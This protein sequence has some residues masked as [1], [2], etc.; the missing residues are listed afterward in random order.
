MARTS[1]SPS[2]SP[3]PKIPKHRKGRKDSKYFTPQELD[4]M[5]D[6]KRDF[7]ALSGR[8]AAGRSSYIR[9][10]IFPVMI[11]HWRELGAHARIVE[12]NGLTEKWEKLI[13]KY[14]GK[15]WRS[16]IPTSPLKPP[17]IHITKSNFLYNSQRK[18]VISE[19]KDLLE[20]EELT[21]RNVSKYRHQAVKRI[22]ARMDRE[23]LCKLEEDI[24]RAKTSGYTFD[25]KKR[26]YL[27]RCLQQ[28][29]QAH[30]LQHIEMGTFSFQVS[31]F[32][33]ENGD[34]KLLIHKH[35]AEILDARGQWDFWDECRPEIL[36]I[37]LAYENYIKKL[38]LA[39]GQGPRADPNTLNAELG[40]GP[41]T[42]QAAVNLESTPSRSLAERQEHYKVQATILGNS[43][44][45][46][47]LADTEDGF[48][49]LP[50]PWPGNLNKRLL[51]K[52]YASY[53]S[54]HYDLA[55]GG[56]GGKAHVP[57]TAINKHS[58]VFF[59]PAYLPR[60]PLGPLRDAKNTPQ[61]IINQFLSHVARR[62]LEFGPHQAFRFLNTY[63]KSAVDNTGNVAGAVKARYPDDDISAPRFL[64]DD[65]TS[66]Y[67]APPT[68]SPSEESVPSAWSPP[69]TLPTIAEE[70]SDELPASILTLVDGPEQLL[71]TGIPKKTVR[72]KR[73]TPSKPKH[74]KE[75]KKRPTV[76]PEVLIAPSDDSPQTPLPGKSKKLTKK[77]PVVPG[78]PTP[79][80]DIHQSPSVER[81]NVSPARDP[82]IPTET[83]SSVQPKRHV[84]KPNKLP[85]EISQIPK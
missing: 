15:N 39:T 53:L 6:Y 71:T 7:R 57:W 20:V 4:L 82:I 44:M 68:P 51:N 19:I 14:V 16:K 61:H 55:R 2:S 12:P 67:V 60:H 33:E 79:V 75:P 70:E 63:S 25:V 52:Y 50:M 46:G 59:H 29:K 85:V 31:A 11:N 18:K 34:V 45:E 64:T 26:I 28:M 10:N 78:P 65:D 74:H 13:R 40:P 5:W 22:L 76:V 38:M 72:K 8:D 17:S 69:A 42:V 73:S 62:Q 48:P 83:I 30:K 80:S 43:L 49:I 27:K 77:R 23:Q 32:V 47:R 58:A 3:V 9:D 37:S 81:G 1:N 56:G 35:A 54:I 24:E 84:Q 21:T 41:L 66:P 36:A